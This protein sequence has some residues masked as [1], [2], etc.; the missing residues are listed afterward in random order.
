MDPA[1]H[2]RLMTDDTEI[3]CES[4]GTNYHIWCPHCAAKNIAIRLKDHGSLP[5]LDIVAAVMEDE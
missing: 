2:I 3:E 5:G 4:Y 1:G